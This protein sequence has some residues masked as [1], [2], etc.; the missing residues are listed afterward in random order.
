M[1]LKK[2]IVAGKYAPTLNKDTEI[3]SGDIVQ[4]VSDVRVATTKF[5]DKQVFDIKLPNEE[6]RSFWLNAKSLENIIDKYGEDTTQWINKPMK[7]LVGLTPKGMTMVIL[8]G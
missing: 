5:G 6:V 4:I 7:A 1:I 3:T 8:K 2:K